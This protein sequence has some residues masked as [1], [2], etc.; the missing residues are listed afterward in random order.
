MVIFIFHLKINYIKEQVLHNFYENNGFEPLIF[1]LQKTN[2]AILLI[3]TKLIIKLSKFGKN[4]FFLTFHI[5][6]RIV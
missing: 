5:K 2:E 4:F 6:F 3:C 1:I